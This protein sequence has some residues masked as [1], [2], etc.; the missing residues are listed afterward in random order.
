M[1]EQLKLKPFEGYKDGIQY[2]II[3]ITDITMHPT[4]SRRPTSIPKEIARSFQEND[5]GR[6]YVPAKAPLSPEERRKFVIEL[7]EKD[8]KLALFLKE[9][10]KKGYKL[11]IALPWEEIPL[12]IGTDVIDFV[13][14]VNGQRILRGL[15]K[16]KHSV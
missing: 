11:L 7:L 16:E 1:Q 4:D 2:R 12:I 15:A 9:E 13:T 14:S 6:I 8:P 3:R 5:P 10:E